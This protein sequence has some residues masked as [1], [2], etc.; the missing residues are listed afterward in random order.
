MK[1]ISN[2]IIGTDHHADTLT[3]EVTLESVSALIKYEPLSGLEI[4][5]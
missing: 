5:D 1:L 3:I 2:G 4:G